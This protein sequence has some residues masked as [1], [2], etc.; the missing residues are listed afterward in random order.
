MDA[1]TTFGALSVA[2]MLLFYA[3]EERSPWFELAFVA[4]C[5]ASSA[6]AFLQGA[7]PFGV[8][9]LI[10]SGAA[11]V[12]PP[13]LTVMRDLDERGHPE[14]PLVGDEIDTL[15]GSL[16]RQRATLAWKCGGLDAAG[17]RATVGASSITLGGL[18]KHLARV[19]EGAFARKWLG[20]APGPP[21]DTVDWKADPDWDWQS[22]AE[23]SPEQLM[24]LWQD[25][26]ARSRATVAEAL[27]RGGLE[28]LGGLTTPDG[29]SPSLRR[30]LIDLVEEYA[31]H[32]GHA[33][34]IRESVDGLTGEDPTDRPYSYRH[35]RP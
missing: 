2:A 14:P 15:L 9:E 35:A 13:I 5:L 23:D 10:W 22:A 27:A 4:A 29:A 32:A 12:G 1:L 28:Q 31:R 6:Y 26:V 3:L 24:T 21:W 11:L 33:D 20:Q 34:L 18:L 30:I 8:V 7:W 19:E 16:E 17:L 25:A